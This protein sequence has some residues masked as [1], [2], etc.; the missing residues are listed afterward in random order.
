MA[1]PFLT[2]YSNQTDYLRASQEA[3]WLNRRNANHDIR[4][5]GKKAIQDATHWADVA[6]LTPFR[7]ISGANTWGTDGG[8]G[9]DVAQV[10]GTADL[11]WN[12]PRTLEAPNGGIFSKILFHANSSV[13]IYKFRFIYG[14]GAQTY[15]DAINNNQYS[16]LMFFRMNT[17]TTRIV[18][19][20]RTRRLPIDCQIWAQCWNASDNA[21]IDFFVGVNYYEYQTPY[22][23]TVLD[24]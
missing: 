5:Y 21:T 18:R 10:F 13:T 24:A 19:E 1:A 2:R 23:P 17:D 3:A 22:H 9:G 11:L 7:A 16:E 14:K 8:S 12:D 20:V 15:T 4:W 6:T